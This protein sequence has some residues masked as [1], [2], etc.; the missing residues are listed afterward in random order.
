MMLLLLLGAAGFWAGMQNA[1]AGG[2][3][4]ITFPALLF[5]GLDPRAANITSTV[6]LFPGQIAMC[7]SGRR[8]ASGVHGL[9]LSALIVIS[10]AGGTAGALL[11]LATPAAFFARLVPWLVLFA[12]LVFALGQPIRRRLPEDVHLSPSILAAI[13]SAIAVYGGYFGGGIGFLMLAALTLAGQTIR[14]AAI[15]KNLLATVMNAA[16]FVVFCVSGDVH[17]PPAM[18]MA[19]GSVA[20]GFFGSWLLLRAPEKL[21]RGAIIVIG[22]ALTL[23]LF[24]R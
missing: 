2:G 10:L 8:A 12:T 23:W 17:W 22:T 19:I 6:A 4:F 1:L 9:T 21:L 5:A 20:G 16:A 15:T 18:A 7:W 14:I 13:Q 24:L 11:L 3:S